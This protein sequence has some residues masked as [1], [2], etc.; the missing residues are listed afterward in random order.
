MSKKQLRRNLSVLSSG[1]DQE[2][3]IF[4]IAFSDET[5]VVREFLD[6]NGYPILVN[7]ILRHDNP[8]KI[9]L[10]RLNNGA[11]LLYQHNHELPIGKVVE[12]SAR[13]DPDGVGRCQI[14]FSA[15]GDLTNEIRLKIIEGTLS[16][17]SFGY[18]LTEYEL[19]GE[20]LMAYFAPYEVSVVSVPAS[21]NVG[22]NRNKP[23]KSEIKL[24]LNKNIQR[25]A[26]T[27][28][29]IQKMADEIIKE[30]VEQIEELELTPDE[31]EEI[32]KMRAKREEEVVEEEEPEEEEKIE[33]TEEEVR[34]IK[35]MR[36]GKRAKPVRP[37]YR[38]TRSR[39]TE[40]NLM[41]DYNLGKAIRAKMNGGTLNGRELEVHKELARNATSNH[42]GIFIPGNAL[43]RA[44][45]AGVT[46]SKVAKIT[47]DGLDMSS[48]LDVVL[49]RSVLGRLNIT[50]YDNL[51]TPL[52]LPKMSKNAVDSF[53]WVD[54][55]GAG[56]ETDI[57]VESFTMTPKNFSGGVPMSKYSLQTVPDLE[58]IVVEHI[59]RGSQIAL[60]K[61][62]FAAAGVNTAK[63]PKSIN[64]M[65]SATA[66]K[67][68]SYKY[69]EILAEI[70]KMRDAGFY[71][72]MTCVMTDATK[73][74]LMTTLKT[75][76]VP[77]YIVD[78][79]TNTMCGLPVETTGLV[80]DN[81]IYVGDW[82]NIVLGSWGS[83]ELDMDDTTYRSQ[84]AIV[85]RIWLNADV[86][87][88][89]DDALKVLVPKVGP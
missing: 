69:E 33:L 32:R 1:G 34:S 19:I 58:R 72:S 89:H 15:V 67:S 22:I 78:E 46:A 55:N 43:A 81:K 2:Q 6:D 64:D 51:T 11:P 37:V 42:G 57:A 76:G 85:P 68:T 4:D 59:M 56:P 84:G 61:T 75:A 13:I 52:T 24:S 66:L 71:E 63:A 7:E 65:F 39:D 18:D 53:G 88:R 28:K 36:E 62:L 45:G 25:N 77:G 12:G 40:Q 30:E 14:Q 41:K 83:V 38:A 26:E 44:A 60:E 10:S 54:E 31:I 47:P 20:D 9:D 8:A 79:I 17:I 50:K 5:P 21:D 82:S 87:Y 74:A 70:A 80:G 49:Q 29:E 35:A 27:N 3:Y 48:F 86:G 23:E 73:A 16:K